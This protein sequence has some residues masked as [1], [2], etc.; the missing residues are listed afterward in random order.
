MID[1]GGSGIVVEN[2]IVATAGVGR[3]CEYATAP[4]RIRAL[5]YQSEILDQP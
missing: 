2:K 3:D 1:N 5:G 4:R